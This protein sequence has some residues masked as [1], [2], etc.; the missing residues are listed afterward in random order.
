M[1]EIEIKE[2]YYANPIILCLHL[3]LKHTR[4]VELKE[5]Y[6]FFVEFV[7]I[8]SVVFIMYWALNDKSGLD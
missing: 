6:W 3:F 4:D 8:W 5:W 1:T 7:R 2:N